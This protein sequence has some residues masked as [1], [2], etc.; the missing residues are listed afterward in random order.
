[1]IAPSITM[2]R[3][4]K[5]TLS[6]RVGEL[7][8][9]GRQHSWPPQVLTHSLALERSSCHTSHFTDKQLEAQKG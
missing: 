4:G 5:S 8:I 7:S 6:A 2:E 9:L 1:M 3:D